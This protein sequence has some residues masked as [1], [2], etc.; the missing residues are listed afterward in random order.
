MMGVQRQGIWWTMLLLVVFL[1]GCA[2]GHLRS[3]DLYPDEPSFRIADDA[4]IEDTA[5]NREILDMLYRYRQA[6]VGKDFGTLN[7]LISTSYYE[8]AG[9]THTTSDDYGYEQLSEVFEMMAEY[10]EEIRYHVIIQD[11][12][13]RNNQAHIDFEFEFAFQYRIADQE[14]WDA[15]VDVNRMEFLREGDVWRIISGM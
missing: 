4:E 2:S 3:D 12:V 15:G 11:V 7:R 10:A 6:L 13:V 14:V 1:T 9:T 8:N 5:E